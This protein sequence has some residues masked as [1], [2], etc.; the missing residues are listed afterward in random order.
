[1]ETSVHGNRK[2]DDISLADTVR[3]S[4]KGSG[5]PVGYSSLANTRLGDNPPIG[6]TNVWNGCGYVTL[7]GTRLQGRSIVRLWL[8]KLARQSS[9]TCI[10]AI[11]C[12]VFRKKTHNFSFN[13]PI[14]RTATSSSW[15][16]NCQMPLQFC[17]KQETLRICDHH[18][19]IKSIFILSVPVTKR[20]SD[21]NHLYLFHPIESSWVCLATFK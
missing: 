18:N 7:S 15:W 4:R 19:S 20:L 11:F 17:L 3:T 6:R 21:C 2:V 5:L 1:M 13:L 12:Y 9:T 14:L 16:L 10:S 8:A